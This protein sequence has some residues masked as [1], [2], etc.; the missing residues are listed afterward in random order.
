MYVLVYTVATL[1]FA[2]SSA[3]QVPSVLHVRPCIATNKMTMA[4]L[5]KS[6]TIAEEEAMHMMMTQ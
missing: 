6:A 3:G 2:C 1:A 5:R 4:D